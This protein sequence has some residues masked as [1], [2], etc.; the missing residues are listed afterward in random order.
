MNREAKRPTTLQFKQAPTLTLE[1]CM[2]EF[3]P[4]KI[5]DPTL[6]Q[7]TKFRILNLDN[8]IICTRNVKGSGTCQCDSGSGLIYNNTLIGI[9]SWSVG[10]SD[11]F[12][13]IYTRVNSQLEWIHQGMEFIDNVLSKHN[14]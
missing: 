2:Q 1:E 7:L 8:D 3:E 6:G 14:N 9:T 13:T 10:C 11:G 5:N 4:L 12:P